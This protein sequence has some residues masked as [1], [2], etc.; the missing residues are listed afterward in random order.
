MTKTAASRPSATRTSSKP[1]GAGRRPAPSPLAVLM[2]SPEVAPFSKT[3]GLGD[4]TAA[5]AA[6]LG[7]LG[8][9]VTVVTPRYRGVEAGAR[10]ADRLEVL[11]GGRIHEVELVERELA[12]GARVLFA[13]CP[14]FFDRDG[15]YGV[16]SDDYADNPLRFALLSRTALGFAARHDRP[17]VVHAHEWQG[18][19]TP[20][21]L[22]RPDATLAA[23]ADVPAVFTIHNLAFQ[24][25]FPPE[26]LPAVGIGWDAFTPAG[27]EF[28]GQASWLKAGVNF[29]DMVTTVSPRYAEEILTPEYG[30]GF[31]GILAARRDRLVGILN[32]IDQDTWDPARDPFL[33]ASYT[34][35]TLAGMDISS[36]VL[37]TIQS[38]SSFR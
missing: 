32:G 14:L 28:W 6:A 11:L 13:D 35:R 31:D 2:V 8:H 17:S 18:G 1:S 25:L 7:R 15:M 9:R 29:A 10:A 12:P 19:L 21:Y 23:L 4:V 36:N 34:S 30:F 38:P 26:A 3:G 5:L 16:G 20:L 37:A 33:P 27:L 22:R 24:G